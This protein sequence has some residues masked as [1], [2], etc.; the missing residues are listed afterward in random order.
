MAERPFALVTV[1]ARHAAD[2]FERACLEPG[3]AGCVYLSERRGGG[4]WKRFLMRDGGEG[5]LV[6]KYVCLLV[7]G[8]LSASQPL[9]E[10]TLTDKGFWLDAFIYR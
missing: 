9:R 5:R 2:S 4:C 7:R 10:P 3:L 1:G 6:V 8:W